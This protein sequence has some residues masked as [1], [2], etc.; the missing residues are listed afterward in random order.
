MGRLCKEKRECGGEER[1]TCHSQPTPHSTLASAC[2]TPLHFRA[3][4]LNTPHP[5]RRPPQAIDSTGENTIPDSVKILT[6]IRDME[7]AFD[8]AKPFAFDVK[9]EVAPPLRWK[10]SYKD[11]E[12][13]IK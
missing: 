8:P 6:D 10:A 13:T 2:T 9:Y 12:V 7:A 3:H 4:P 11:L 5:R 1:G